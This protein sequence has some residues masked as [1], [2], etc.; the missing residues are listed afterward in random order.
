[1]SSVSLVLVMKLR[2]SVNPSV[3]TCVFQIPP[4]EVRDRVIELGS[5][6]F[7][8]AL[9][10]AARAYRLC[11]LFVFYFFPSF[12]RNGRSILIDLLP[13]YLTLFPLQD[14]LLILVVS[15]VLVLLFPCVSRHMI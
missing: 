10:A 6:F 7:P 12:R 4:F 15:S 2:I 14:R 3:P 9:R 5:M 1:M 13:I 8:N 11:L